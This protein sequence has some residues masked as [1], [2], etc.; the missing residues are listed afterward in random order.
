MMCFLI[1]LDEDDEDIVE[2]DVEV[3]TWLLAL[4][5]VWP[6][7]FFI[8]AIEFCISPRFCLM[9]AAELDEDCFEDDEEVSEEDMCCRR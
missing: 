2:E 5:V 6:I 7:M 1:W 4:L 8:S 3:D 9:A